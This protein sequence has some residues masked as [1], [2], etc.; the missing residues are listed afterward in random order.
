MR[1]TTDAAGNVSI[2]PVTPRRYR[3]I[4]SVPSTAAPGAPAWSLRSVTIGGRDVTDL[5]IDIAPGDAPSI[6]VTFTDQVSELSGRLLSATGEPM[7]D[8]YVVVLPADKQYWLS[9]SRRVASARPDAN[10]RYIFRGLPAGEYRLAAT[11]DL[12]Q[13]DLSDVNALAQLSAQAA[14]VTLALGEKKT[15]DMK[16]AK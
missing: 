6:V 13:R 4:A 12:L 9:Q 11:T 8:Y 5:P 2:S 15:F 16:I 10:G 14:P 3:V 1:S 7:T